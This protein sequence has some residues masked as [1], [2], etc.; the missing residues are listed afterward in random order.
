MSKYDDM[1]R[2]WDSDCHDEIDGALARTD[3][4][5]ETD[6]LQFQRNTLD[7]I[8]QQFGDFL[9]TALGDRV[10]GQ[11][12][13]VLNT[14]LFA[15]TEEGKLIAKNADAKGQTIEEH[16]AEVQKTEG[17]TS[18]TPRYMRY[19]KQNPVQLYITAGRK[20]GVSYF[21]GEGDRVHTI[22]FGSG[23]CFK[24]LTQDHVECIKNKQKKQCAQ[25]FLDFRDDFVSGINEMGNKIVP[26]PVDVKL[27]VM[28]SITKA[29][30]I[31]KS[32]GSYNDTSKS[33]YTIIDEVVDG[34][35][36]HMMCCVP[37]LKLWDGVSAIASRGVKRDIVHAPSYLSFV[38]L[39][40]QGDSMSVMGNLDI[41]I[42]TMAHSL[43][44]TGDFNTRQIENHIDDCDRHYRL[45]EHPAMKNSDMRNKQQN[46]SQGVLLELDKVL[47]DATVHAEI[48]RCIKFYNDMSLRLQALKHDHA[49]LYFVNAD[50]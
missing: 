4:A 48:E 26:T 31:N 1:V 14:K 40:V 8:E 44:T 36:T 5:I 18:S 42:D 17:Y 35:I 24:Y 7:N 32:A 49:S 13:S 25:D 6:V 27:A 38:L 29:K 45:G 43:Q 21:T 33:N 46:D 16:L 28:S 47:Q 11:R 9:Y 10:T 37:E 50:L 3:E 19:G 12:S 30:K 34:Q 20:F 23:K 41:G 22:Y 39:N 2:Q 15:E